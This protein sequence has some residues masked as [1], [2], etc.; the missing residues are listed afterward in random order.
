MHEDAAH[1]GL[2]IYTSERGVRMSLSVF[3][4]RGVS[5]DGKLLSLPIRVRFDCLL[6]V[7]P[8]RVSVTR[9]RVP[10]ISPTWIPWELEQ[11]TSGNSSGP[12]G[13]LEGETLYYPWSTEGCYED[14]KKRYTL[15]K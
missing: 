13:G 12:P 7:Q 14:E 6:G 15:H 1:R 2:A 10:G 9:R 4:V 3:L 5:P 11:V 8:Q